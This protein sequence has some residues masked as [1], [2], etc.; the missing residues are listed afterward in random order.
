MSALVAGGAVPRSP[1]RPS[2]H[3]EAG[4]APGEGRAGEQGHPRR[5]EDGQRVRAK[6]VFVCQFLCVFLISIDAKMVVT[7][8]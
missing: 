4:A 3:A 5:A 7:L 6:G 2:V 8:A 1:G